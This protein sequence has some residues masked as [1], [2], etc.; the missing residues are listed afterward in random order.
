MLTPY[1]AQLLGGV[2]WLAA[3]G[4][5]AFVATVSAALVL[6]IPYE[7]KDKLPMADTADLKQRL[8]ESV[9]SEK[10]GGG[11]CAAAVRGCCCCAGAKRADYEPLAGG[12][13]P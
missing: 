13:R 12:V 10:A 8:A 1:V 7:T 5:Y 4:T 3:Y 9:E 11:C 6:A 2:S